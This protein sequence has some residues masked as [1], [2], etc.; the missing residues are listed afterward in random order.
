MSKL[1]NES[2]IKLGDL[3]TIEIE[4]IR[5]PSKFLAYTGIVQEIKSYTDGRQ[6]VIRIS[7]PYARGGRSTIMTS[8]T[9]F[10]IEYHYPTLSDLF[11]Y[12]INR[13]SLDEPV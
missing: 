13:L 3:L 10:E 1:N 2:C 5:Y 8:T 4:Q 12:Y 7:F 11:W 6:R 9:G